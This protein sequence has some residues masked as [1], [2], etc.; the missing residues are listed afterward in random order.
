MAYEKQTWQL[1]DVITKERIDHIEDGIYDNS[2]DVSDKI[3]TDGDSKNMVITGTS[4]DTTDGNANTWTSVDTLTSGETHTNIFSKISQMFKNIRYLYSHKIDIENIV[5]NLTTD[6]ANKVLSAKQGK[7]LN[8][9]SL[10]S[11]GTVESGTNLNNI[12]QI[13]SY[14]LNGSNSYTNMPTGLSYGVLTVLKGSDS[15][16]FITQIITMTSQTRYFHR[17]SSDSGSTWSAWIQLA[18][19]SDVDTINDSFAN[20]LKDN[21]TITASTVSDFLKQTAD[22]TISLGVGSHV[23]TATWYQHYATTVVSGVHSST[24]CQCLVVPQAENASY[25]FIISLNNSTYTYR[26]ITMSNL[27]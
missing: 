1:G 18:K 16:S 22:H 25:I 10:I 23:F 4:S 26:Q 17:E 14:I 20:G 19:Q 24:R 3:D 6:N 27:T 5:D 8:D 9:N 11:R 2:I 21:I 7:I 13:G 12:R 15:G